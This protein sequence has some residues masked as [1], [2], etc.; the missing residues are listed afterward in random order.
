MA[1]SFL[2]NPLFLK[3]STSNLA[4]FQGN[5]THPMFNRRLRLRCYKYYPK[6]GCEFSRNVMEMEHKIH[7]YATMAP[8][9]S[10]FP[11]VI[12][13]APL[14]ACNAIADETPTPKPPLPSPSSSPCRSTRS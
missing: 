2:K 12:S 4:T 1:S 9:V 11:P 5:V 8:V 14:V 6:G 10:S 13:F 3:L 7:P